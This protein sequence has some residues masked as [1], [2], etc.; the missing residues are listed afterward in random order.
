MLAVLSRG[1]IPGRKASRL[2]S[3][4]TSYDD[5]GKDVFTGK[6]AHE[7]LKKHGSSQELLNSGHWTVKDP[8]TVA[9]AV[10]DW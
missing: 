1:R 10:F 5:Y 8:D 3:S 7:Y 2:V 6:V 9:N 4:L